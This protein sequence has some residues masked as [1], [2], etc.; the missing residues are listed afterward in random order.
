MTGSSRVEALVVGRLVEFAA[1]RVHVR[2]EPRRR[3]PPCTS[4]SSTSLECARPVGVVPG[5]SGTGTCR[6]RIRNRSGCAISTV[7]RIASESAPN[8]AAISV[9]RLDVKLVGIEAP[10][11]FIRER[12]AGLDAEQDFVGAARRRDGGSGNR[13]S[14]PAAG[15]R[16]GRSR[17]ALV[18]RPVQAVVLDFEIEAALENVRVP[19]GRRARLSVRRRASAIARPRPRGSPTARSGPR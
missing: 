11:R 13:W 15:R 19:F 6:T 3:V 8:A 5:R 17:A 16:C 10:A 1:P 9:G 14:R 2:V 18:E 4:R 7:L 12:L